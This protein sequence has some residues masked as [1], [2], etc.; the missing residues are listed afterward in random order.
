MK[1]S[2]RI[3]VTLFS[4]LFSISAFGAHHENVVIGDVEMNEV[5]HSNASKRMSKIVGKWENDC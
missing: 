5:E 2:R 3:S 1:L 4:L